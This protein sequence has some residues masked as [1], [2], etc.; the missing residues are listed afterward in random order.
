MKHLNK[1]S[2]MG[3]ALGAVMAL[4]AVA[5]EKVSAVVID[6][7]PARALWVKE[8]T[9]FFIPEVNLVCAAIDPMRTIIMTLVNAIAAM[10]QTSIDAI[11]LVVQAAINT[12]AF[13]V[14]TSINSITLVVQA[15]VDAVT[16][17]VEA[18]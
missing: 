10:I 7:Y 13:I 2:L 3:A 1:R 16:L 9:N 15:T 8:F 11:S 18:F 5:Q 14:Q 17:V 4:P 6:G 12:V